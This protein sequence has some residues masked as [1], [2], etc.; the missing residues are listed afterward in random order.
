MW[1]GCVC[2]AHRRGRQFVPARFLR[3]RS[4]NRRNRWPNTRSSDLALTYL[5]R[6][7]ARS[8]T[9]YGSRQR[10]LA[11]NLVGSRRTASR[12]LRCS[13]TARGRQG[14]FTGSTRLL[15][16][17]RAALVAP[18]KSSS[19]ETI[20]R[21]ISTCWICVSLPPPFSTPSNSPFYFNR[22]EVSIADEHPTECPSTTAVLTSLPTRYGIPAEGEYLVPAP[23]TGGYPFVLRRNKG[24]WYTMNVSDFF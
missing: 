17:P 24:A 5:V 6:R 23:S 16:L 12:W 15:A 19:S 8:I 13:S 3:I 20:R 21:G 11:A 7:G 10:R 14:N 4:S 22:T 1:S 18:P 2:S 9:C